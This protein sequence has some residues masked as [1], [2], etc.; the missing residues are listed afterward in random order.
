MSRRSIGILSAADARNP[1]TWSGTTYFSCHALEEYGAKITHLGPYPGNPWLYELIKNKVSR[2]LTGK[3]TNIYNTKRLSR[4]FSQYFTK[5]LADR[6]FDWLYAPAAAAETAFLETDIPIM[7][8]S[9]ANHYLAQDYDSFRNLWQSSLE[10]F[11]TIELRALHKFYKIAYPTSWVAQS[12]IHDLHIPSEKIFIAPFGANIVENEIPGFEQVVRT[13]KS[14][15]CTLLFLGVDWERKGGAIA[16]NTLECLRSMN[17]P[18]ELLIC[19]CMPP[20]G[21]T[22]PH[23]KVIPFL[24]KRN[25]DDRYTIYSLLQSSSFLLLPTRAEAYGIVFC[26]ASAFG[27]PSITSNVGGVSGV[28]IEEKNGHCLPYQSDGYDYAMVIREIWEDEQRYC[29][30]SQSSREQY[31]KR[32]NWRVWA[33]TVFRHM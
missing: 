1:R 22:H 21:F 33:E 20:S 23:M 24:D 16:F 11:A 2:T 29:T 8:L 7:G 30:L 14:D 6:S 19:G 9:D 5:V 26:E 31:E 25:K 28:V 18:A 3:G 4:K 15:T 10:E 32:L 12:T 17:I 13:K 27:L